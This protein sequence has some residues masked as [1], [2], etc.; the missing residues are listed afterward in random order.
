MTH[1]FE[2]T[3]YEEASAHQK[4]WGARLIDELELRGNGTCFETFRRINVFA[5]K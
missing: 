2:G 3:E 1:E 5:R 4:A